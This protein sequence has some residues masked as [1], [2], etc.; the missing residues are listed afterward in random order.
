MR[1]ITRIT[2]CGKCS[3]IVIGKLAAGIEAHNTV[4]KCSRAGEDVKNLLEE[5]AVCECFDTGVCEVSQELHGLRN[6]E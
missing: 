3:Q 6:D 1:E 2:R 5:L 4:P